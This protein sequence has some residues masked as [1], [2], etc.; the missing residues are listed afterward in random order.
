MEKDSGNIILHLSVW[1]LSSSPLCAGLHL[2]KSFNLE[3]S[4]SAALFTTLHLGNATTCA[5]V[6]SSTAERQFIPRRG[7]EKSGEKDFLH[8]QHPALPP[9]ME[10]EVIFCQKWHS[11]LWFLLLMMVCLF[12]ATNT[13]ITC[14]SCQPG[15]KW[16]AQELL[17][18]FETRESATG[19]KGEVFGHEDGA[20]RSGAAGAETQR[21]RCAA[22]SAECTP[23]R[24]GYTEPRLKRN[25]GNPGAKDELGEGKF[26]KISHVKISGEDKTSDGAG[27]ASATRC[28]KRARRNSDDSKVRPPGSALSQDPGEGISPA[29]GRRVTRSELRWSGEERR[30]AGP[31]QEELKLNSSTF[32]L[33]G[34]SSHNQAMVHWSGQN[35]S[36]SYSSCPL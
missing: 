14:S 6:L 15:N 10:R 20:G 25:T 24:A 23:D 16:R 28:R 4:G 18:K 36:V 26:P 32:A 21:L 5:A 34:D 2:I 33:T 11:A 19:L 29:A 30:A 35:S 7:R 8:P 1:I 12:Q 27:S 31:R 3:H 22:G 9:A 13:E 17:L